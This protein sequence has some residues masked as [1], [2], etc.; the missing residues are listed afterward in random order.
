MALMKNPIDLIDFIW[1]LYM[2]LATNHAGP[3]F[4]GARITR[5]VKQAN[6]IPIHV[7]TA[8]WHPDYHRCRV[9]WCTDQIGPL[10]DLWTSS[11]DSYYMTKTTEF[12]F[13]HHA[14]VGLFAFA[15]TNTVKSYNVT[16]PY[17]PN[18][19]N[20][21]TYWCAGNVDLT[22]RDWNVDWTGLFNDIPQVTFMFSDQSAAVLF[23]LTHG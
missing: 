13:V 7:I 12:R 11:W 10:D 21:Q 6:G 2:V 16:V 20:E 22:R 9:K 17:R 3:V 14:I 5:A 4:N 15:D 8:P 18:L 1:G 19:Y 23:E